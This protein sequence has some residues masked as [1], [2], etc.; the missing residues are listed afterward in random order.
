MPNAMTTLAA[1]SKWTLLLSLVLLAGCSDPPTTGTSS[2]EGTRGQSLAGDH[3]GHKNMPVSPSGNA[4][5]ATEEQKRIEA[6]VEAILANPGVRQEIERTMTK[7]A[8]SPLAN[9][10]DARRT[11]SEAVHELAGTA[12]FM[13]AITDTNHPRLAWVLS[14]PRQWLGRRVP[15]SR[16]A[17]DNVDNMYRMGAIDNSSTYRLHMRPSGPLPAQVSVT[18]YDNFV[19]E[20]GTKLDDT[21]ATFI[22]GTDTVF[23]SDGSITLLISPEPTGDKGNHMESKPGSRQL[24]VR[25]TI[26]DW[27]TYHPLT[28]SI[29]R[30]DE[31]AAGMPDNL[32]TFS[33]RAEALLAAAT[34]SLLGFQEKFSTFP[35]NGF[36]KLISRAREGGEER[37]KAK[38]RGEDVATEA[39]DWGFVATGSFKLEKDEALIITV[40]PI[41][42][43]FMGFMLTTPWLVSLEHVHASGSRNIGQAEINNDGTYTYVIAAEDPGIHNWLDTGGLLQGGMVIR[44]QEMTRKIEFPDNIAIRDIRKV[45]LADL[46]TEL[47]GLRR[48]TPEERR[49]ELTARA[50]AY[51]KRCGGVPCEVS[52]RLGVSPWITGAE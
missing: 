36:S 24:L 51:Y 43:K 19:G 25:E 17:V 20:N 6:D 49:A 22:V 18:L 8:A 37:R 12:A 21:L 45:P 30:I 27:D 41:G 2:D 42:A 38:M 15:G 29:E 14:A 13:A 33:V 40:D 52:N 50:A 44:W 48:V 1:F 39:G 11:L 32:D 10:M 9:S 28:I 23:N 3:T 4:V 46:A 5:I 35:D 7:L 31:P 26:S 34:D 47:P 16:W